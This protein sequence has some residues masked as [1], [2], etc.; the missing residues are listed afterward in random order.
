MIKNN[1]RTILVTGATGIVGS[2]VVKQLE[3]S[4]SNHGI[5]RAAIHSQSK[6]NMLMH[7]NNVNNNNN[8]IEIVNIDY[9]KPE[10]LSPALNNV[11]K[12][13]LLTLPAP[14]KIGDTFFNVVKESKKNG[15][16]YI[17]KL[18][19]M[20]ADLEPGTTIGRL[21]RQ[22]EKIIEESGIPY[23]IL[24]P[25]GFMQNFVRA[26]LIIRSKSAFYLPPGDAKVSFVDVRDVAAV[27]TELLLTEGNGSGQ[28]HDN[29][30][31]DITGPEVLSYSQ[32]AEILSKETGRKI[33]YTETLEEDVRKGMKAIGMED[34][35]I[36]AM[37]EFYN[38]ALE[39]YNINM[40]EWW[41]RV[42]T[43][44]E[45]ITGRK[46]ISFGQF[47]KDYADAFR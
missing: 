8:N 9:D 7:D 15:I 32:A 16:N 33:S 1:K 13:F 30:A 14:N 21:H 2:E 24:R 45:Q 36:D 47:A 6:T 39:L 20:G 29:N 35:Y 18:S 3:S 23:T 40:G 37:M 26:G 4:S 27:A 19:V 10:T 31:Y 44:A 43:V 28:Q 5:I 42:T 38:N 11:D 17:V 41:S 34:W 46:P 22:E 25:N 12:L